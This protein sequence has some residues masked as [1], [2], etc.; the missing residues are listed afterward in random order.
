MLLML[1]CAACANQHM[2]QPTFCAALCA[3]PTLSFVPLLFVLVLLLLR[4]LLLLL[5]LVLCTG[6]GRPVA[7]V[8]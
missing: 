3:A 1:V 7:P 4:L 8:G 6:T 5:L 2:Q